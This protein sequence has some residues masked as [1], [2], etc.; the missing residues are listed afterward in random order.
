[1]QK[2]L[3]MFV[4]SYLRFFARLQIAK[5]K[6]LNHKLKII[7][8]TGSA[9][10]TS[11]IE[12]IVTTLRP[13]YKIKVISGYNSESGIPLSILN[14]KLNGY[15]P[16]HWAIILVL[17][18]MMLIVNWP[19]YDII[20][21]EMG[22][23]SIKPPK[24]MD[25]LLTIVQPEI[26]IFL[27][28]T[29]VHLQNFPN[30]EAI[31]KEKAKL[32]NSLPKNGFAIVNPKLIK[33]INTQATLIKIEQLKTIKNMPDCYKDTFGAASIVAKIFG[34]TPNFKN[35]VHPPGRFG[36][37]TGKNNTTIIDSTYNSSPLAAQEFLKYLSTFPKPRIAVLGDMRELGSATKEEHQKLLSLAKKSADIV[38]RVGP[39]VNKYYWELFDYPFPQNATILIK[40]S[41]NQV[42]LEELVKH[43]LKNK[44]DSKFL[45]RQT[46]YWLKLKT[47]FRKSVGVSTK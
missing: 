22:I 5:L 2:H 7:G 46:P 39:L 44:S 11:T 37:F 23:D 4:L 30:L 36:I 16:I 32:I 15:S 24:N 10:K 31:A 45:C 47:N 20:I 26:G 19:I 3:A 8:V 35:Y 33:Y 41:Q 27:S 38:I 28:V 12:A 21:V 9:G 1:M 6:I 18:P 25:Y 17:A 42:F 14:L 29:P 34:V 43:L 13:K 40:G